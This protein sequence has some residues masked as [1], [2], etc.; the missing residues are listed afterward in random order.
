MPKIVQDF[1]TTSALAAGLCAFFVFASQH[2]ITGVE[3][4][5]TSLQQRAAAQELKTAMQDSISQEIMRRLERIER[6]IDTI[7]K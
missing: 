2:W 5:V 1:L 6:K 4:D 3:A 7:S